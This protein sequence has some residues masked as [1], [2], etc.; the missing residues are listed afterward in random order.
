MTVAAQMRFS[1]SSCFAAW[2]TAFVLMLSACSSEETPPA[3]IGSEK[4]EVNTAASFSCGLLTVPFSAEVPGDAPILTSQID[5]NCFAWWEFI[6]LN[7]PN[8][9][10]TFGAPAGRNPVQWETYMVKQLLF[11]ADGGTPP[12]WGTQPPVPSYCDASSLKASPRGAPVRQLSTAS[13]LAAPQADEF[14]FPDDSQQAAPTDQP[15]WLGAQNGT[16][17]W[18]EIRLNQDEYQYVVNQQFY[19]ANQQLAWIS[20][21]NPVVLPKG[22]NNGN[23]GALELKAAWMEV[24]NPDD[25]KWQRYKLAD[26]W[27]IDPTSQQCRQVTVAL[28]GLHILHKTESQPTWIW[29]TFE[30]V[31]NLPDSAAAQ[32]PYN[33][34]NADCKPQQVTVANASCLAKGQ[35]S[36]VTVSCTANT[37]P[38]YYL[39]ENCPAP[40]P[41][42][43]SRQVP[44]DSDAKNANGIAQKAIASNYPSSVFQY[45]QLINVIWSTSPSQDPSKPTTVPLPLTSMLPTVKVANSTLETYVQNLTCTDCHRY[46]TIAATSSEPDPQ[47]GSDFSFAIG[48][49][50]ASSSTATT[51]PDDNN[52]HSPHR[53]PL[54]VAFGRE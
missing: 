9:S 28:V 24:P 23:T 33:F 40:V 16:N 31:D 34:Y 36:P 17:V 30:H 20:K 15:N 11:P 27:V 54:I 14:D 48:S 13:K 42:Q 19:D 38:P 7:W 43:V 6:A 3:T 26:T 53:Q 4:G 35:S 50:T 41:I 10:T 2:L 45:Y 25:A 51:P 22:D 5:V 21:G 32:A 52:P 29:A 39:G 49:A 37:P 1:A 47:W 8:D 12:A 44:L 18:Y 46:A